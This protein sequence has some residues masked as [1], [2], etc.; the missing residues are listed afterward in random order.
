M[1]F[2]QAFLTH[3]SSTLQEIAFP[4]YYFSYYSEQIPSILAPK[5]NIPQVPS[6]LAPSPVISENTTP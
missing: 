3:Q 1:D 6:I 4:C 5:V 2:Q